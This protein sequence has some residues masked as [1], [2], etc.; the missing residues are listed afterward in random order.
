MHA[1][2][3]EKSFIAFSFTAAFPLFFL[4][5]NRYEVRRYAWLITTCAGF[6]SLLLS[7]SRPDLT[8]ILDKVT[9]AALSISS[10]PHFHQLMLDSPWVGYSTLPPLF[11]ASYLGATTAVNSEMHWQL[12]AILHMIVI[13]VPYLNHLSLIQPKI[14][15]KEGQV[16]DSGSAKNFQLNSA[17]TQVMTSPSTSESATKKSGKRKGK[18][19]KRKD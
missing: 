12:R 11:V 13:M 14:E 2:C 1:H 17:G 16:N 6:S 9:V 4:D 10:V 5:A 8:G 3:I 15:T 18:K 19:K 7:D